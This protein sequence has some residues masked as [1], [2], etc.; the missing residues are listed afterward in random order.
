MRIAF[1]ILSA[2]WTLGFVFG[3]LW[4]RRARCNRSDALTL[5]TVSLLKSV[6][7]R[8]KSDLFVARCLYAGVPV[9]AL[10]GFVLRRPTNIGA[11]PA[12]VAAHS[13]LHQIQTAA[14]AAALLIM[15]VAGALLARSRS[16]QVREL[17]EKLKSIQA[18][19]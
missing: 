4:H 1:R 15:I 8:A 17:S 2:I 6:V 19:L 3:L 14:G 5:D 10:V 11:S 13:H 16:L 18:D 12:A 7:A 9:G